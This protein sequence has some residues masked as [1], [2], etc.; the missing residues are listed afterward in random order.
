MKFRTEIETA[1]LRMRFGYENRT[2]ALGSCFAAHIAARL[3]R[4]KFRVEANPTGI[5]FNPLS[6]AAAVR[7]PSCATSCTPTANGGSISDS[8]ATSR[9]PRPTRRSAA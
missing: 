6:V 3:S 4:A 8:T 2:L 5:L 9:P 7:A 1:P